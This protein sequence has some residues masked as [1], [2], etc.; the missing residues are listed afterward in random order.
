MVFMEVF[1]DQESNFSHLNHY[2]VPE[3]HVGKWIKVKLGARKIKLFID[4]ELAAVHPRN[5]GLHQWEMDIYHYLKTFQK[6]DRK[7]T[8][9]N[10]S[11]VAISY[12]VFCL[13]K[14]KQ[15]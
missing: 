13:K 9:L 10:S 14:K 5:W 8:R 6:K 12:A 2:S 7:S 11:H 3:G 1:L 4:N 15:Q